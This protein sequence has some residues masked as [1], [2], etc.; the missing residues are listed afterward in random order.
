MA[1]LLINEDLVTRETIA[2]KTIVKKIRDK[3]DA[4]EDIAT[5]EEGDDNDDESHPSRTLKETS[6]AKTIFLGNDRSI[7]C[8]LIH[9]RNV[10]LLESMCTKSKLRDF[11]KK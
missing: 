5:D 1:Y 9:L 8:R 3:V 7:D 10:K 11:L 2:K 6:G 4:V